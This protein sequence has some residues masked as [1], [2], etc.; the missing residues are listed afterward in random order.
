MGW[1]SCILGHDSPELAEAIRSVLQQGYLQQYETPLHQILSDHFCSIVPC[2]ERLRLVN[3]GLEATM[4]AVRIARAATQRPY[5]IKFEGHF[6]GL[7]DSLTWNVDSSPRPGRRNT[8]GTLELVSGTYGLP[9]SF[10]NLTIPVEWNDIDAIRAVFE[11]HAEDIAGVILEPVALNIGCISPDADF[12]N[13]LRYITSANGALLIFDEILTGF[14]AALGGA[15]QIY[16]VTPDIATYGKAFG[17]GAPIAAVA[18]AEKYMEL[19][20]PVGPVQIS[21]TNTGRLLTVAAAHAAIQTLSVP[22]FY[23]RISELNAHLEAGLKETFD[24]HRVPVYVEGFGGRVGAHIGLHS[25]PRTMREIEAQYNV[26]YAIEL[27]KLLT[28]EY[29]LY[30]FLLPLTYCPEPVTISAR[31]TKDTIDRAISKL[32]SALKKYPYREDEEYR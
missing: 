22:G 28:F 11:R 15:Q 26:S 10:G 12:L 29:N 18:G 19:I 31:H 6:H 13:Q 25:R 27:F 16:Q 3:S 9:D 7:N 4:Y 5:I 20:A 30:G 21:G 17:C 14:R 1:G 8:D 23:D 32:D 2:A 24:N